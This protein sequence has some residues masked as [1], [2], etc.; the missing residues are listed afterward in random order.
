M[1]AEKKKYHRITT[2]FNSEEDR[3]LLDVVALMIGEKNLNDAILKC[4]KTMKFLVEAK[5]E[6]GK[7]I[8]RRSDGTETEVTFL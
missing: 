6:G 5:K 2:S 3:K 7:V 4:F 1:E 8:V